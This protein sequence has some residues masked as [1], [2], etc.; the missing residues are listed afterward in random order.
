MRN[1]SG[2]ILGLNGVYY[3]AK[4]EYLILDGIVSYDDLP[5]LIDR[6]QKFYEER[7]SDAGRPD[8]AP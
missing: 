6:L 4:E 1:S 2:Y 7:K 5:V 3:S 8:S